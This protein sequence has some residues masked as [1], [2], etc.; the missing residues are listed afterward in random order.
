MKN[1][2]GVF[3]A[4]TWFAL[5]VAAAMFLLIAALVYSGLAALRKIPVTKKFEFPRIQIAK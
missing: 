1:L 5:C 2:I 4:F 3:T